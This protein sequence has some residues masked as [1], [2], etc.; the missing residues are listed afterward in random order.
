MPIAIPTRNF[1]K[2]VSNVVRKVERQDE[3]RI[4]RRDTHGST[5][6]AVWH[7]MKITGIH[8]PE[9]SEHDEYLLCKSLTPGGET[10]GNTIKVAIKVALAL[11]VRRPDD[12]DDAAQVYRHVDGSEEYT[13]NSTNERLVY[14]PDKATVDLH[15]DLSDTP[16]LIVMG[17]QRLK[18][19]L[20][21]DRE[22][23][24]VRLVRGGTGV[25]LGDGDPD[26]NPPVD[27]TP[28]RWEDV[29][30]G[31]DWC[32]IQELREYRQ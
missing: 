11:G 20:V 18:K 23:R 12:W 21:I 4:P 26:A 22:I 13:Y 9:N 8:P 2:R 16:T 5:G 1:L 25:T 17:T 6:D 15:P 10:R 32:E 28:V 31:T 24:A 7:R 29:G 27:D 3:N 14:K 19:K 30:I